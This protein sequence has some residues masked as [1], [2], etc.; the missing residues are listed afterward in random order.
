MSDY[1]KEIPVLFFQV[2]LTS[3]LS[4]ILGF[5]QRKHHVKEE[6]KTTFG[7]DRTF[8]FIGLFGLALLIADP[9]TKYL[10]AGG[11]L[12]LV[13]LL[14]LFYSQKTKRNKSY[15]LTTVILAM[16]TY[17][18]PLMLVTQPNWFTM[19]FF[20][21]ILILSESKGKFKIF[22]QK[23]DSSEFI[24]LAKF[25]VIV[26]VILPLV[27]DKQI[28]SFLNLSPYKVWLAI[29]VISGIS[30]LSYLLRKYV[31]PQAGILLTGVLGGLY[32]S[33]STTIILA[34]KSKMAEGNFRQYAAAIIVATAMMVLRIF[35]LL[36]IF[37]RTLAAAT[38]IWFLLLFLT[39]LGIAY[40]LNK[41]EES[42]SIIE[43][44]N[45]LEDKNPLEFRV[46]I[47]FAV[48]YVFFSFVTQYTLEH[49]GNQ[50]LNVLSA[51]VGFTDIDP[52][53]LNLFQGKYNVTTLLI[54]L[55]TFQ[56]IA[57]NNI[58]KMGYG[59]ALGN[60]QMA[61]YLLQ[62]FGLIILVN[63]VVIIGLH[64]YG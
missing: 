45:F 31:F 30:Y 14:G 38:S 1:F 39:S 52:F 60:R 4:L 50:G 43:T 22:S 32:S 25:I 16:L 37:N 47:V 53:L 64:I 6:E 34:R 63:L 24:T 56:A 61:K 59:I 7:T 44:E 13:F 19:I 55:A 27:P 15:G 54:S 12:S 26:G 21:L 49:F 29:V 51:V 58:L 41:G 36:L 17:T 18:I 40:F 57:S 42:T 46:A 62:G 11:G 20:V 28:F 2:I 33:T 3:I 5:E 9:L 10:Y 23:F 48:L 35:I 8:T